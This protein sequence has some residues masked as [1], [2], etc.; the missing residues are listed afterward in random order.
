MASFLNFYLFLLLVFSS[1]KE[2]FTFLCIDQNLVGTHFI[3][4]SI[5]DHA[6]HLNNNSRVGRNS[7]FLPRQVN[8]LFYL[9]LQ[10]ILYRSCL[11][12]N[13]LTRINQRIKGTFYT[14]V[15]L[16]VQCDLFENDFEGFRVDELIMF[17]CVEF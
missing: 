10:L 7:T 15:L 3:V 8:F 14:F 17:S 6:I 13:S 5:P 9:R 11:I 4:I 2:L 16:E 12:C 1:F